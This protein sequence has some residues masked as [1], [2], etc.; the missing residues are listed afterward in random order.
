MN[1]YERFYRN[2]AQIETYHRYFHKVFHLQLRD[3][4]SIVT[5]FDVVKFDEHLAVPEGISTREWIRQQYG[6]NA[7]SLVETLIGEIKNED[8]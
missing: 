7:V 8:R 5:G 6:D 1:E 2:L 3:Y 4:M